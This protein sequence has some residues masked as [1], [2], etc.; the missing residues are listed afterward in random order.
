MGDQIVPSS[1]RYFERL[2]YAAMAIAFC[3]HFVNWNRTIK[4]LTDGPRSFVFVQIVFFG[5][6]FFGIWLVVYRRL[7]WARW[8]TLVVHS[9]LLLIIGMTIDTHIHSVN[10]P[11]LVLSLRLLMY[12]LAA[13]FLFTREATLWFVP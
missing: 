9:M 4:H 1:V 2:V 7:N 12:F 8:A 5:I 3:E 10:W 11:I 6:Q 13:C